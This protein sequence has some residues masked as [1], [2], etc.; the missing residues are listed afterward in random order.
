MEQ[1][2]CGHLVFAQP[3]RAE[4]VHREGLH[5]AGYGGLFPPTGGG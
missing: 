4:D 1:T 3:V 2:A 5:H